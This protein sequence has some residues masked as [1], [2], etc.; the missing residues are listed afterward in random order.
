[1]VEI[2]IVSACLVGVRCR[3]DGCS[4]IDERVIRVMKAKGIVPVP[5]C[6]EQLSG[7]P[8]PR[9]CCEII[10]GDGFDVIKGVARVV[11]K[12]GRD[13]T[14]RFLRGAEEVL[15]IARLVNAGFAVMKDLSPSCGCGT[16][17]DGTFT[18]GKRRGFGVASAMLKM[19][20]FR[21]MSVEE[22]LSEQ[23]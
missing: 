22:F 17:Y 7:L 2:V 20:G 11:T 3:Y 10:G 14:N 19:N 12:S 4:A 18:G 13:L 16:I 9:E 15:K 23:R 5:V 8:T 1:M 21:V 6:P